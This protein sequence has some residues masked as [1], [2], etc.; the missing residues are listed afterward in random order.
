MRNEKN[1]VYSCLLRFFYC[2]FSQEVTIEPYVSDIQLN[3]IKLIQC[4]LLY[5]ETLT[6]VN[7]E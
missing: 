3:Y 5:Q 2:L 1:I 7:S 4:Q 6:Y